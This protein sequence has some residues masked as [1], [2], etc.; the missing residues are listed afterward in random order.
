MER[1]ASSHNCW[2]LFLRGY[3]AHST[4]ALILFTQTDHSQ[5][6]RSYIPSEISPELERLAQKVL[7]AL[8]PASS[9]WDPLMDKNG[10]IAK[11]KAVSGQIYIKA[12]LELPF[13]VYDVFHILVSHFAALFGIL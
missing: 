8:D 10:L 4:L 9:G 7:D 11:K 6:T 3:R 5:E 2:L 12:E 1:A 13:A